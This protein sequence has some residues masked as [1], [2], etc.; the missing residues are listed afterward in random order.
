MR[1]DVGGHADGNAA[2]TVDEQVGDPRRQDDGL[3]LLL[4]VV[5][6]E[7]DCVLVDV[8]QQGRGRRGHPGLGVAHRG[9]HIAVNRA[10][11]ALAVD[12]HQPHRERLGHAHQRHIDRG[13]TVRVEAAEHVADD[14]GAFRIGPVRRHL[15]VVHRIQ[16][17]AVH[18]LQPV[19]RVRQGA[20]HDHA[21]GVVEIRAPQLVFDGD[22]G[23][24]AAAARSR[25]QCVVIAVV[26]QGNQALN[27]RNRN[28]IREPVF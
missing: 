23:D 26:S 16:D 22:G 1:R 24:V 3:Q 15:Q 9:R 2:R 4:V 6:L 7:I 28:V 25:G 11:I 14:A 21:H 5:R 10:E 8:G 20:A 19:A 17:A 13:V 27:G 12:Q 18:G